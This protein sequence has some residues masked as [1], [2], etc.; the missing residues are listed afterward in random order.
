MD[1]LNVKLAFY[2]TCP[3]N[4]YYHRRGYNYINHSF[5]FTEQNVYLIMYHI[6]E[7]YTSVHFHIAVLMDLPRNHCWSTSGV[8][9]VY[10]GRW[11]TFMQFTQL[12]KCHLKVVWFTDVATIKLISQSYNEVII[13]ACTTRSIELATKL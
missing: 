7:V 5:L 12:S 11:T 2:F 8:V 3:Y 9:V 1:C 4:N 10:K 6:F 13:H